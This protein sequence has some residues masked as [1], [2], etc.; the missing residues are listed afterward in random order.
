MRFS[1]FSLFLIFFPLVFDVG[2]FFLIDFRLDGTL[3]ENLMTY[4][5]LNLK[6]DFDTQISIRDSII[7][8]LTVGGSTGDISLKISSIMTQKLKSLKETIEPPDQDARRGAR[9]KKSNNKLKMRLTQAVGA[10]MKDLAKKNLVNFESKIYQ[11]I[12]F[13][14]LLF[15]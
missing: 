8:M 11:R 15:L 4:K 14:Y 10:V 12:I 2:F 3:I 1:H 5:K 9:M 6:I 13:S 7:S